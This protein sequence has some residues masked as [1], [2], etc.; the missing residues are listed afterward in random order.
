M[1]DIGQVV[2]VA[3]MKDEGPFILEWIAHY[4]AIGVHKFII[5]TN[6]C[7][8]G[9]DLILDRLD[10]LGLVR[11]LPNPIM[12]EQFSKPIQTVAIKYAALQKEFKAADWL[13]I[14]DTDEFLN[15][16]P[17]TGTLPELMDAVGDCDAISFNQAVFGNAGVRTFE[18]RPVT[19][20][21]FHRFNFESV[22]PRLYP[23]MFGIKTL[24]RNREDLF[25]RYTNHL[26][27]LRQGRET[28]VCWLDGSGAPMHPDFLSDP[29]RS[30]PAYMFRNK[31][32]ESG[33]V[34]LKRKIYD[35]ENSTHS[36]GYINHYSLKSLESFIVQSLRGDA[37]SRKVRRDFGY[38]RSYDRNDTEDRS[39]LP[40]L[41]LSRPILAD[42]KSDK[43]L[44]PLHD[45]AVAHH[46][47]L[48]REVSKTLQIADLIATCSEAIDAFNERDAEAST[49]G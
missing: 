49:A 15:L 32:D 36:M 9:T 46:K 21:F 24:V 8:D 44:G 39:I 19:E 40:K 37:V 20:Q 47:A 22:N 13:M 12:V 5:I 1:K 28:E 38:W 23:M 30:Y 45:K 10:D 33:K 11:H 14:V 29:T 41:E 6:D 25:S 31:D 35:V 34:V 26:P 2:V 18:D 7:S 17:G 48:F 4:R 43:V 16:T 27:R 3:C 42:L